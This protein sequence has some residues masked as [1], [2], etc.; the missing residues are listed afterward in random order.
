MKKNSSRFFQ[1][2][3]CEFF[4]C[5]EIEDIEDFNCLFCFCPLYHLGEN[6]GGDYTY[7]KSGKK[8]CVNCKRPHEKNGYCEIIGVLKSGQGDVSLVRL[9]SL[10]KKEDQDAV[11]ES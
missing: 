5:H 3:D 10:Q 4:P 6:C 11:E 2:R 7:S 1:N 8:S 9:D